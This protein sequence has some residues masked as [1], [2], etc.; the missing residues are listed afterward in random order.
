MSKNFTV[1][2]LN[3]GGHDTSAAILLNGKLI[4]ACEEERFSRD[5]HTRNFPVGAINECLKQAGIRIDQVDEIALSHD[6][7]AYIREF[8]L[9]RAIQ[10]PDNLQFLFDDKDRILKQLGLINDVAV[11][12]GYQG[13]VKSYRHH[14]CH[15]ASAYYPSGLDNCLVVSNDGIGEV[16]SGAIGLGSN[17]KLSFISEGPKFPHSLGL[18][19]SAVTWYLGWKNHCDEGIIM[20]LAPYGNP[21]EIANNGKSFADNFR[22]IIKYDGMDGYELNLSWIEFHRKRNTWVSG[23]FLNVFGDKRNPGEPILDRHKHIAAALQIVL[24]ET[25]LNIL[26]YWRNKYEKENLCIAGGVGLN[27]SLNGK[28]LSSKL[29]KEVFVQPAAGDAGCAIGAC[30]LAS[31]LEGL[32]FKPEYI[33]KSNYLGY[34]ATDDE[35]EAALKKAGLPERKEKD[36]AAKTAAL[37]SQGKIVGWFQGRAEFGPRALG[38]RSILCKPNPQSM[39]DH[40]NA[41]VKFREEFR[42]FAPAV[43]RRYANKYFDIKQES[44]HMLF[45]VQAL[46][47]HIN[48]IDATVHV[49]NSC[50]VQTVDELGNK[51]FADLLEEFFRLTG[52]PVLLNTSFNIKG[53]PVVNNAVDAVGCFVA[54]NIDVLVAGDYIVEKRYV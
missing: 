14:E 26:S 3:Y 20:G 45:A 10:N 7:F 37:L 48:E 46:S 44:P 13:V 4:A 52:V 54:T 22:N 9:E 33:G 21:N 27:C 30:I 15:L 41:R 35:I 5:K 11:R 38:N 51:K 1:L 32:K 6:P 17:G 19:Y 8:Y 25:V 40:V 43:L 47:E 39:R 12:C 31:E 50:R 23:Q 49:D 53:M 36:I 2:G 16:A 18:L 42:P 29:F 28:I 34:E 24:E